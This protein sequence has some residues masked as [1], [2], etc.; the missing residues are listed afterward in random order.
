[1]SSCSSHIKNTEPV[2]CPSQQN[3]TRPEPV[4][5]H[6][7]TPRP[8]I[9]HPLSLGEITEA[10]GRRMLDVLFETLAKNG[11]W[12]EWKRFP[13]ISDA[14]TYANVIRRPRLLVDRR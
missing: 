1:V 2:L 7:R 5:H 6:R 14:T 9:K 3:G 4:S 11:M 12:S 13:A 10:E 8:F